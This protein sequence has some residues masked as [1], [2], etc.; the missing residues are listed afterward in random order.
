[1]LNL[2][3]EKQEKPINFNI[4]KDDVKQIMEQFG[5][6]NPDVPAAPKVPPKY[7]TMLGGQQAAK[8]SLTK[9]FLGGKYK[10]IIDASSTLKADN[11]DQNQ[12]IV[13]ILQFYFSNPQ[14]IDQYLQQDGKKFN[15]G[16]AISQP[17]Y[18]SNIH[19]SRPYCYGRSI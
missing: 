3:T 9:S 7:M 5:T 11:E 17:V 13:E 15:A 16:E 14:V 4:F 10:Y 8:L 1:M 2:L 19:N 18:T 6:T 12:K